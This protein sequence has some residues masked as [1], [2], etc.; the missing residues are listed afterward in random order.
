MAN[1]ERWLIEPFESFHADH[2]RRDDL[3]HM[4]R[5]ATFFIQ[6]RPLLIEQMRSE[7]GSE[8]A[9]RELDQAQ[10][11]S[12]IAVDESQAGHPLLHAQAVIL[13]WGGLEALLSDFLGT[14]LS[15]RP[16]ARS[17]EAVRS[18]K[19]GFGEYES[20]HE[21][22]RGAYLLERLEERLGS[23]RAGGVERFEVLFR[24]F[25]MS[26]EVPK[27]VAKDLLELSA[28]RNLLVHRRGIVDSRFENQC[29]WT[30][31]SPGAQLAV[32]HDDYHRYFD[33]VD[34]YV[35][36][37]TQRLLV[38]HGFQRSGHKPTCRFHDHHQEPNPPLQPTSGV[39]D[40]VDS[41]GV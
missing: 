21:E 9:D 6:A 32:S 23:K 17:L 16:E 22:E 33:A 41:E 18:L 19:I 29:P 10:Y 2:H 38:H 1:L 8:Q 27:Q 7:L 28:V 40:P 37:V 13:L 39:V 15:R 11:N 24:L 20:F 31:A 26:S 3:L 5:E 30:S 14:W 35:F 12:R 4:L 36:E 34:L 25:G